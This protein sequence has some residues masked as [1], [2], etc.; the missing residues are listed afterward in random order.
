MDYVHAYLT[1]ASR[2]TL[3]ASNEDATGPASRYRDLDGYAPGTLARG[4]GL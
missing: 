4:A 1:I 3:G 2:V